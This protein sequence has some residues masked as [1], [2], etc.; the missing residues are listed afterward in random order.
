M[1]QFCL[2]ILPHFKINFTTWE[3]HNLG[4]IKIFALYFKEKLL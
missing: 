4:G 1:G 2:E 3:T